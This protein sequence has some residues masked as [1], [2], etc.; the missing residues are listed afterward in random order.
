MR[1]K[2]DPDLDY[3]IVFKDDEEIHDNTKMNFSFLTQQVPAGQDKITHKR[4]NREWRA[5]H[6][7]IPDV[8]WEQRF[9]QL[10]KLSLVDVP[11]DYY[12][13]ELFFTDPE[14]LMMIFSKLEEDNLSKIHEQ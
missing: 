2:A 7:T 11:D 14:E 6:A 1:H 10:M 5:I 3:D 13:D 8:E 12:R 4:T 9:E